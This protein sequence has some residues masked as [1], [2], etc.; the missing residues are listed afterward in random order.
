MD[1]FRPKNTPNPYPQRPMQRP[2]NDFGAPQRPM[3]PRPMN[4][5]LRPMQPQQ[6]PEQNIAQP[7]PV[8]N[9]PNAP[10]QQQPYPQM[11]RP[12]N[13]P[14]RQQPQQPA[15]PISFEPPKKSR[16]LS[17][18]KVLS[19]SMVALV[20]IACSYV[21]IATGDDGSKKTTVKAQNTQPAI[22]PLESAGFPTYYPNP[23]P[24]G[25]KAY[26]GSITYY[27]DSFTFI[28]EQNGQKSFFV[29]EQPASTDPDF[30]TLKGKLAAPKN[31][32]LTTGQGIEGELDSGTVTAVKTDKNTTIIVDCVKAVCS[33]TAHDII[34][35]MQITSDLESLRKSNL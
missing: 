27:K 9:W 31:I 1:D 8:Q 33:T 22:K 12:A 21:F 4:N 35:N 26:K 11:Q 15:Q 30:N 14:I 23:M 20:L 7:R 16:K 2:M 19:V 10:Q 34:S 6:R 3:Q 32:A 17:L 29:Y 24:A 18:K 28:L 5:N 25:L 13:Q